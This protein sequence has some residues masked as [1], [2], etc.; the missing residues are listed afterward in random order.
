MKAMSA[1][2]RREQAPKILQILPA[3]GWRV[4]Y[5]SEA[6]E[7][8]AD[9]LVCWALISVPDKQGMDCGECFAWGEQQVVG[10]VTSVDG[11][12]SAAPEAS[13]FLGYSPAGE[14]LDGYREPAEELRERLKE[15]QH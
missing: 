14:S 9:V 2:E 7:P 4:V 10:I 6:G 1:A 11:D 3:D 8:F 13:N 12:M 15:R 5:A